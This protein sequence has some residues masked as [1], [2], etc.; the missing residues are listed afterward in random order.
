MEIG[1]GGKGWVGG[2]GPRAKL[3]KLESMQI[4]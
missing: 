3:E 2:Y 4:V 1:G